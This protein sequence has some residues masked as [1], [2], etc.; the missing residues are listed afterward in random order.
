MLERR[1]DWGAYGASGAARPPRLPSASP[2]SLSRGLQTAFHPRRRPAGSP[3]NSPLRPEAAP[4]RSDLPPCLLRPQRR[5][6]AAGSGGGVAK[7]TLSPPTGGR[8]RHADPS[9]PRRGGT[10]GPGP[11]RPPRSPPTPPAAPLWPRPSARVRA[12][13][14]RAALLTWVPAGRGAHAATPPPPLAVP[15]AGRGGTEAG[16]RGGGPAPYLCTAPSGPRRALL[17]ARLR[18]CALRARL[19]AG[20]AALAPPR[21]VTLAAGPPGAAAAPGPSD[22]V[23]ARPAAPAGELQGRPGRTFSAQVRAHPGST[24]A[25]G[26]ERDPDAPTP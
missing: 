19:R 15:G 10:P 26:R 6:G 16:A 21:D 2:R 23:P 7:S 5:P 4:H 12:E 1:G 25:G 20:G 8:L 13:R 22:L 24:A 11:Q 3:S 9:P 17:A 14:G 18:R